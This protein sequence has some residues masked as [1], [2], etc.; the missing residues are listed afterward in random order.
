MLLRNMQA[1][2]LKLPP[3][4]PGADRIDLRW[5]FFVPLWSVGGLGGVAFMSQ[6]AGSLLA[7]VYASV[8]GFAVDGAMDVISGVRLDEEQEFAG[9]DLSI[10][11]INAYPEEN[12]K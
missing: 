3:A 10:H 2:D 5:V 11:S 12:V 1:A 4:F 9:A 7:V 6:L 8:R